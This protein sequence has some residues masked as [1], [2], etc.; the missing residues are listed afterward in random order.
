M[1]WLA[2]PGGFPAGSLVAP[3]HRN[4]PTQCA[5]WDAF[6]IAQTLFIRLLRA[7][8]S[9]TNQDTDQDTANN[10][11]A[12]YVYHLVQAEWDTSEAITALLEHGAATGI[13]DKDGRGLL[14]HAC[15]VIN[16]KIAVV[17]ALLRFEHDLNMA[18]NEGRT[19]L[20][21]LLGS[22]GNKESRKEV[23]K[24]LISHGVNIN[25]RDR[26][27]LDAFALGQIYYDVNWRAIVS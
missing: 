13:I 22:P 1:F 16:P 24:L 4:N 27:G 12:I 26:Y 18:D 2:A 10:G 8:A 21:V 7:E 23:Y 15:M 11:L 14:H 3:A 17:N 5:R 19:A 20:H 6:F 9:L 25:A